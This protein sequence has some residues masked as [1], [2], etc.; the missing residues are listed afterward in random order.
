MKTYV[1]TVASLAALELL[2][3][4]VWLGTGQLPERTLGKTAF[5]AALLAVLVVWGAIVLSKA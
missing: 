1:W 5:D 3:S 2:G 4:L